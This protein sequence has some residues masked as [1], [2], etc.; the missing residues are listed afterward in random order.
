MQQDLLKFKKNKED[1]I[2]ALKT[3]N[4][5]LSSSCEEMHRIEFQLVSRLVYLRTQGGNKRYPE[6][7]VLFVQANDQEREKKQKRERKN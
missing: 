7:T 4:L 1:I 5:Q 3:I 2:T 6:N